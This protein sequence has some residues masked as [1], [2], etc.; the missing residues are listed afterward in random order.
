MGSQPDL[1]TVKVKVK[2]YQGQWSSLSTSQ[3]F[4]SEHEKK[5]VHTESGTGKF[6]KAF[7]AATITNHIGKSRRALSTRDLLQTIQTRARYMDPG[8][9]ETAKKGL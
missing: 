6:A 9:S 8:S 4:W 1:K 3:M 7:E 2:V 5:Q